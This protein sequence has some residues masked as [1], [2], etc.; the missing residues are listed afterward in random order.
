MLKE[1]EALGNGDPTPL[2]NAL[3][4][5]ASAL[6]QLMP[7]QDEAQHILDVLNPPQMLQRQQ[8]EQGQD[9]YNSPDLSPRPGR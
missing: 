7:K 9:N 4:S 3:N 1:L 8:P 2:F 5:T 6:M